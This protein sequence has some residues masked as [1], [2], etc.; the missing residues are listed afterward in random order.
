M[1][2]GGFKLFANS[3]RKIDLR[4]FPIRQRI[5]PGISTA[6]KIEEV[7]DVCLGEIEGF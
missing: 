4:F 7:F 2:Q 6:G 3:F 5:A 1:S